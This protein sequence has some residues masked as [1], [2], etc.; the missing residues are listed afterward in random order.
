MPDTSALAIGDWIVYASPH[1]NG[2]D[3]AVFGGPWRH[4]KLLKQGV[5]GWTVQNASGQTFVM[6]RDVIAVCLSRGEAIIIADKLTETQQEFIR[7]RDALKPRFQ[8]RIDAI[9][10]TK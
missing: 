4:A 1:R 6:T 7:E 8:A 5:D 2:N 10:N 3:S 9:L